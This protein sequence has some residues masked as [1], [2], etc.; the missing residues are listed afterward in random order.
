[1]S[2]NKNIDMQQVWQQDKDHYIHPWTDFSTFKETGS[3]ILADSDNVHVKDGE[4]REYLDGIGGLWCVNIG[5][6][7][8]EMAEAIAEGLQQSGITTLPL[9]LRKCDRSDIMVDVLDAKAIIVGSPTLNNN[10]FPTLADFLTY[11]KGLRPKN[12]IGAAFGSY[13]WSGEAVKIIEKE[14]TAMKMDLPVPGLKVQ[15]VPDK[16][17]LKE[18]FEF[19]KKIAEAIK[20]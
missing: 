9:A 20:A 8:K 17:A 7:R 19:G 10:L 18:C 1:M 11:M 6:A 14:L 13:G 3:M 12:R 5:Y 2:D 4:G 16:D 15:Y